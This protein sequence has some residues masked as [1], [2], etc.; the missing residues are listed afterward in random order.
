MISSSING[1]SENVVRYLPVTP[2]DK[3][4][5]LYV[6]GTGKRI[7]APHCNY[8]KDDSSRYT[9]RNG[10]ILPEF[11][12]VYVTSGQGEFM[13]R[14]TGKQR[15]LAGDLILLF[16]NVWHNYRPDPNTGWVEYWILFNGFQPQRMVEYDLIVPSRAVLRLDAIDFFEQLFRDFLNT[17]ETQPALPSLVLSAMASEI[18]ANVL[19]R[20]G[21]RGEQVGQWASEIEQA[22]LFMEEHMSDDVDIQALAKSL[23]MSYRNFRRVFKQKTGMAPK[24]YHM[25][26]RINRAKELLEDQDNRV[27]EVALRVGFGDQLYFSR[28]FRKYTGVSPSQWRDTR[29][30][31]VF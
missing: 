13:S 19:S 10:R 8:Y 1:R 28:M 30:R 27:N 15:V 12:M 3:A 9:W 6:T 11:G 20:A 18:L 2:R 29:S 21:K 24:Q 4:W 17:V 31:S 16:P 25:Q 22:K 5:G 26:L 7:V 14:Q 23:N